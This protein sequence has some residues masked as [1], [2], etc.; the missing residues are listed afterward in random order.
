MAVKYNFDRAVAWFGF[1]RPWYFWNYIRPNGLPGIEALP[2]HDLAFYLILLLTSLPFLVLGIFLT[3]RRLRSS[4][5]PLGLCT[6]FFVPVINLVFFLALCVVPEHH[7]KTLQLEKKGWE[8]LLPTSAVG[9]ALLSVLIVGTIGVGLTCF[10]TNVL[11]NYGWG[12]FVGEPFAMGLVSVLIYAWPAKRTFASCLGVAA[13]TAAFV[14]LCL[15]VIA[16]EGL[17]CLIIAA[18]IG[19]VLALF[20]GAVGYIIAD[21]HHSSMRPTQTLLILCAVPFTMGVEAGSDEASP[22]FSVT[23]SVV[24]DAPPQ[25]VWPNV[26]SFSSIPPARDWILH[27]GV[28]YPN[29]A[30]IDGH[31]VGAVRHCIFTTGEFVEPIEI[32][33]ENRLLRFSVAA[34]PEP[35]EEMSPYPQLKTPH[36]HGYFQTNEGELRLTALPGGKTL[37]E[38]TTWYTNRIWPSGYWRVWS[39]LI[40]HHIHLRVLNHIKALSERA[41]ST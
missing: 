5:L 40:I 41:K 12:L 7:P 37:L 31:G 39:N 3:L 36:L 13:L 33:D 2:P 6:L 22:L 38:G 34:Q 1:H 32:W 23:S 17:I 20:G 35:M 21:L 8:S 4:G 27:T 15:L 19:V 16:V 28:A 25:Q 30:R 10:S 11:G 14:G 9:S 29:R 24:I 26:L 18:P